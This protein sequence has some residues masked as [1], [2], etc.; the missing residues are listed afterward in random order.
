MDGGAARL[1][2]PPFYRETAAGLR[3]PI[4]GHL[5]ERAHKGAAAAVNTAVIG[6]R[7]SDRLSLGPGDNG[8]SGQ[9]LTDGPPTQ[10]EWSFRRNNRI[11]ELRGGGLNLL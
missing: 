10:T 9:L 8:G 11:W 3:H 6:R 4:A 1:N 2:G 7:L 5:N